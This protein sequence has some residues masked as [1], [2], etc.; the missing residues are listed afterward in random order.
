MN[1]SDNNEMLKSALD[2]HARGFCVIPIRHQDKKPA[3]GSWKRYQE[4]RPDETQF[5]A[6]PLS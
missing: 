5:A 1:A 4:E 2:Y 6:G 3:I